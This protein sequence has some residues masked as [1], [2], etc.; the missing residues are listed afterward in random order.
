MKVFLGCCLRFKRQKQW[1]AER[2]SV[3]LPDQ[4]LPN[5][6]NSD[7]LIPYQAADIE[8][9]LQ[10]GRLGDRIAYIALLQRMLAEAN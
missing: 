8:T 3:F 2:G 7:Y 9:L 6:W 1:A 10:A 5:S 4:V